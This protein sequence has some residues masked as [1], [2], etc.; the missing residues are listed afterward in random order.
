[1]ESIKQEEKKKTRL[2]NKERVKPAI[3]KTMEFT[4]NIQIKYNELNGIEIQSSNPCSANGSSIVRLSA[5]FH[6]PSFLQY[7]L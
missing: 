2:K 3:D 6:R 5:T 4:D 7:V 1:M